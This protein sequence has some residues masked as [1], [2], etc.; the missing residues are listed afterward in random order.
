MDADYSDLSNEELLAAAR[1]ELDAELDLLDSFYKSEILPLYEEFDKLVAELRKDC[2][3]PKTPP[4]NSR[5]TREKPER[6]P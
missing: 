4:F 3:L 1:G 6:N 2:E 5:K